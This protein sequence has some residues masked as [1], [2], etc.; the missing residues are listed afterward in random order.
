MQD[1]KIWNLIHR[2]L[3]DECLSQEE[4]RLYEWLAEDPAHQEFF[5]AIKKVWQVSPVHDVEVDFD[6]DWKRFSERLGIDLEET[7]QI[8]R[9]PGGRKFA[10]HR[11]S[12]NHPVRQLLRVAAILLLIAVPSYYVIT[13]GS[14]LLVTNTETEIAMQNIQTD[15]GERASMEFSDGSKVTLNSMSTLRFPKT[16]Q[17][18]KRELY[19]EGEAFF[20]VARN[21]DLPFV[22]HTNGVEVNVLGTEFNV[23][24]Y[25]ENEA[26]EVVVRDGKVAVNSKD[27]GLPANSKEQHDQIKES[28]HDNNGVILTKGQRTIVKPGDRPTKPENVPLAPHLAWVNGKMI[29]DGTPM[30]EVIQRLHR[31]YNLNFKVADST[32]LSKQLKASFKRERLDKVLGI[33]SFS[34]DIRYEMREDTVIFKSNEREKN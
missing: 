11:R 10:S 2:Y 27:K 34:L 28:D 5:D 23:N 18:S 20:Q 17:G 25:R 4:Q 33:I 14:N 9:E 13:S 19:L 22:V 32:L 12:K 6:E 1:Q 3:S 15:R 7:V 31:A 24:S 21:E 16:F 8:T 30:R 29:F 26:V